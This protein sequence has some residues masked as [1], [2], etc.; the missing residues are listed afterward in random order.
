MQNK[1]K[2][3]PIIWKLENCVLLVLLVTRLMHRVKACHICGLNVQQCWQFFVW[4]HFCNDEK[5]FVYLTLCNHEVNPGHII[6]RIHIDW[7]ARFIIS[8]RK[9]LIVKKILRIGSFG[10]CPDISD[11]KVKVTRTSLPRLAKELF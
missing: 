9:E 4:K 3:L 5:N 1:E 11:I 6:Y 7:T 8:N 2:L 10:C